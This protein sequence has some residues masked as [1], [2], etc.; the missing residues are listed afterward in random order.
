MKQKILFKG[1]RVDNDDSV[2]FNF[3]G[4][5]VDESGNEIEPKRFIRDCGF[6]V[7]P[8]TVE[9]LVHEENGVQYF[10]GDKL[11]VYSDT[12]PTFEEALADG[13][14]CVSEIDDNGL[15]IIEHEEILLQVDMLTVCCYKFY[16]IT[17]EEYEK[18]CEG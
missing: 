11:A 10:T 16:H 18:I 4:A 13:S 3:Y 8:E 5:Y 14:A 1:H 6:L 9:R 17:N 12:Y 7:I 2:H 15:V